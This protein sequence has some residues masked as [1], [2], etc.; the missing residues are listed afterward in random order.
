MVSID[1]SFIDI[2]NPMRY[3]T[4]HGYASLWRLLFRTVL[5]GFWVRVFAAVFLIL[6]FWFGV[7]RQ[8]FISGIIFFIVSIFITYLGGIIKFIFMWRE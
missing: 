6:A 8:K 7:Y 5:E 1:S 2:F 4:P 3:V